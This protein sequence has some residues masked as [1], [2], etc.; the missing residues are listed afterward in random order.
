M[1]T[2][3]KA[4][5]EALESDC[6][7]SLETVV[8]ERRPEDLG[9]LLEAVTK[10]AN[11]EQRLKALHL[12]GR[13]KDEAAVPVLTR[14]IPELNEVERSRAIDALGRIGGPEALTTVLK[15]ATDPSPHVRKFVVYALKRID[16]PKAREA[17]QRIKQDDPAEFVRS[18]V[19]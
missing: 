8:A 18:T 3:S 17:L 1:T 4:L 9:A 12:L 7:H 16:D 15:H 11:S 14:V 10:P 2:M 6:G 13:W 19:K 5:R